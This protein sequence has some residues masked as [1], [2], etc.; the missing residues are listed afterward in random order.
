MGN[1]QTI[2]Q[3]DGVPSIQ[4]GRCTKYFH[5]FLPSPIADV[6]HSLGRSIVLDS[7]IEEF[8]PVFQNVNDFQNGIMYLYLLDFIYP[9][10]IF[11]GKYTQCIVDERIT[12]IG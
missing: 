1:N 6:K 2:G 12:L 9:C 11:I 10:G 5:N 4:I 3:T 8:N 7:F